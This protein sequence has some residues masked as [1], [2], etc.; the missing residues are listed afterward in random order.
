MHEQIKV[1]WAAKPA[2][3]R[4]K[5]HANNMLPILESALRCIS[6]SMTSSPQITPLQEAIA[7]MYY[8]ATFAPFFSTNR[9]SK[10]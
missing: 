2:P 6:F 8:S 3:E 10:A 7:A 5:P 1:C 9:C 4:T